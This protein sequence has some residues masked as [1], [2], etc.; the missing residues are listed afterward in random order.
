MERV[1]WKKFVRVRRLPSS[2]Q[3]LHSCCQLHWSCHPAGWQHPWAV[4]TCSYPLSTIGPT[5]YR[6]H[7]SLETGRPPGQEQ[8]Q[9]L[10]RATVDPKVLD[11]Y[12]PV[13][14]LPSREWV[15]TGPESLVLALLLPFYISI[16]GESK[17][18]F[19]RIGLLS[20][21]SPYPFSKPYW[22]SVKCQ[23]CFKRRQ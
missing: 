12:K 22:Q 8:M 14:M 17:G 13:P 18:V 23:V 16:L 6:S 21:P 2:G 11:G 1:R 3:R 4:A 9:Y 20:V 5:K 15:P 10:H 7:I 19:I